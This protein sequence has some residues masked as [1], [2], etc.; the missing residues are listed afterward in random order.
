MWEITITPD[1][2]IPYTIDVMAEA[3]KRPSDPFRYSTFNFSCERGILK[4][5]GVPLDYYYWVKIKDRGEVL[6][7]G[8]IY[9]YKKEGQKVN[10]QCRGEEE[11][12][13]KRWTPRFGYQLLDTTGGDVTYLRLFHAFTDQAPNQTA[14]A[15]NILKNS[16]LIMLMNSYLQRFP[17]TVIDS[18]N[19]IYRID[20]WGTSSRAGTA[21]AY[22]HGQLLAEQA[23]YADMASTDNSCYRDASNLWINVDVSSYFAINRLAFCL[24]NAFDTHIR[25]GR[26]DKSDTGISGTLQVAKH[27]YGPTLLNLGITYGLTPHWRFEDNFTF[28][29]CI[30]ES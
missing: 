25:L 8:Y 21:P 2:G 29:D 10:V 18:T 27:T 5:M 3:P 23:T 7:R 22:I 1:S 13:F 19:G 30:D 12:A 11:L 28:L 15:Y 24:Y 4:E 14:D 26:L 17:W 6:F 16:G 9:Y 20:G